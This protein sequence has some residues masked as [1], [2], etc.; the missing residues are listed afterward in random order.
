MISLQIESD[1]PNSHKIPL[2][3]KWDLI[4]KSQNAI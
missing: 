2:L 4:I 1:N 3:I